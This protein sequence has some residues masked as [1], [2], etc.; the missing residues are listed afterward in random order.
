MKSLALSRDS[1][2]LY[3]RNEKERGTNRNINIRFS[4]TKKLE[5]FW[6][7]L[8][9]SKRDE[10]VFSTARGI[11][12]PLINHNNNKPS[13]MLSKGNVWKPSKIDY[14]DA[15]FLS[16]D[17]ASSTQFPYTKKYENLNW[18]TTAKARLKN[19]H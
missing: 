8:I 15:S 4:S 11:S 5:V 3:L 2:Q 17:K 10:A 1:F 13:R 18:R 7:P 9:A 16:L 14:N 6:C 12:K 19:T